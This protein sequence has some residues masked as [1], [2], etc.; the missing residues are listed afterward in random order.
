MKDYEG[1]KLLYEKKK[2]ENIHESASF[3]KKETQEGNMKQKQRNWLS[4]SSREWIGRDKRKGNASV[5]WG[6]SLEI[7][8]QSKIL[9]T[10]GSMS[11]TWEAEAGKSLDSQIQDQEG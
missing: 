1:Q 10:Q 8:E 11:A 7:G 4:S 2:W 5:F 3:S 6:W 9:N